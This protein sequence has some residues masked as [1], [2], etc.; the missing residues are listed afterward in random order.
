[1]A[2]LPRGKTKHPPSHSEAL[3][4]KWQ[5]PEYRAKMQERDKQ[6]EQLRRED[7]EKFSR[8]GVPNGMRKDEANKLWAVAEEQADKIIQTLKAEGVLPSVPEPA[9]PRLSGAQGRTATAATVMTAT[10][11]ATT[12]SATAKIVVPE[13]EDE[14]AEAV[15]REMF[16]LALGPTGMRPKLQALNTCQ[17][18]FNCDPLSRPMP[19]PCRWQE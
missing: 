17:I 18:A 7:P 8:L 9:Q 13:T 16:K 10:V 12:V 14:M 1:M 4:A 6:R 19:T 3:K 11:P 2:R 15:L 5:D